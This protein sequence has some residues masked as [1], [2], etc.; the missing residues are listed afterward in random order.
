MAG[1]DQARS[2]EALIPGACLQ[3]GICIRQMADGTTNCGGDVLCELW[4]LGRELELAS[5]KLPRAPLPRHRVLAVRMI[6]RLFGQRVSVFLNGVL[7]C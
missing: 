1:I 5:A 4:E 6:L 7:Q 2:A 3:A